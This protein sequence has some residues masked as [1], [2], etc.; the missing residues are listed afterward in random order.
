MSLGNPIDIISKASSDLISAAEEYWLYAVG[1]VLIICLVVF[2]LL[3]K[4]G[5]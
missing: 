1:G 4:S 5:V 2:Y 3:L